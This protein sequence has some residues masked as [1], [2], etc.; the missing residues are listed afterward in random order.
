MLSLFLRQ[1]VFFVLFCFWFLLPKSNVRHLFKPPW[2]VWYLFGLPSAECLKNV[3]WFWRWRIS[4]ALA[5]HANMFYNIT[6]L[7]FPQDRNIYLTTK[8]KHLWPLGNFGLPNI[9]I[10]WLTKAPGI[11]SD[12]LNKLYHQNSVGIS[13]SVTETIKFI[14][15]WQH[16]D[17]TTK[18]PTQWKTI[19]L[20][21]KNTDRNGCRRDLN[22]PSRF[23]SEFFTHI[24]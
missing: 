13:D 6:S 10:L 8:P 20:Q 1:L 24:F 21:M 7:R 11:L 16:S 12:G 4:R 2:S 3:S 23:Y 22:F 18:V 19:C 17:F 5:H 9:A 15:D 14:L